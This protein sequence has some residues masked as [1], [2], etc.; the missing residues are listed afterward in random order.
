M[1]LQKVRAA[2]HEKPHGSDIFEHD[3]ADKKEPLE[4]PE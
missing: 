4:I 2:V 1:Y 3:A